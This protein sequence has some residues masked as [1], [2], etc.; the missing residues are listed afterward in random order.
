MDADLILVLDHGRI[1]QRGIHETL[2]QQEGIYRRIYDMQAQ[3]EFELERELSL[4]DRA[5]R[6]RPAAL[7]SSQNR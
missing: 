6:V 7:G 4:A 5:Q 1:V 3:V 2:M